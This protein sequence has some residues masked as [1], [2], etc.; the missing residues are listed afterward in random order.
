MVFQ[1][2]KSNKFWNVE[3]DGSQYVVRFGRVGTTGQQQTKEFADDGKARQAFDKLVAEKLK[4]GYVDAAAS[5]GA[6]SR[7]GAVPG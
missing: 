6:Y 5:S 7:T 2:G 1:D 4:K 3:L